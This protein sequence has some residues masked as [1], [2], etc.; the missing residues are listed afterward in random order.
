MPVSGLPFAAR[1]PHGHATLVAEGGGSARERQDEV[2][3]AVRRGPKWSA[4]ILG[5][6]AMA[7][8]LIAATAAS[9][10]DAQPNL[11]TSASWRTT[12]DISGLVPRGPIADAA[13]LSSGSVPGKGTRWEDMVHTA[14]LDLHQLCAPGGAVAAGAG[15]SWNYAWP[16]DTAFVAVAL[17]RTG[18]Q[19][20][21]LLALAFLQRVQLVDGGFEARYLLDG[22]GPP[23]GRIRQSDGAGWALWAL[24]EVSRSAGGASSAAGLR[25]LLDK[26]SGF[27]LAATDDGRRIPPASPDYW[28]VPVRRTSLGT[29]APLLAGLRAS[30][31]M[32]GALGEPALAKRSGAAA[33]RFRA[34]VREQ[35][36][37]GY[38]R[39]GSGWFGGGGLDA[40][41]TFLMPPFAESPSPRV[42]D[43]WMRYQ[44]DALRPAGGLAPGAGWKQDGIS[45][46]PE[47]A[48][49]AYTAAMSGRPHTAEHWMDWL[50]THRTEWGSLPEKVLATGAPAGP[51]PLAWTAA[52]VV[53]TAAELDSTN[54]H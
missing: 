14:L 13:W 26:S 7:V 40:A 18:H 46:T 8:G 2:G 38:A 24:A 3:G 16:R 23:D 47:T 50:N 53:L 37:D 30:E 28:E 10:P 32:Y 9:T 42:V 5:C 17:A 4:A 44:S 48:L 29:V 41:V 19:D 36:G 34:I 45:W 6:L 43:A 22:S 49:V 51:A 12:Q 27:A 25:S 39:F 54:G 11:T 15:G 21:A 33:E 52:L 20:E 35:F 1:R 31:R